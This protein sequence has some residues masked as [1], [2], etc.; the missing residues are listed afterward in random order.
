MF[1][2]RD[3]YNTKSY[4]QD[5]NPQFFQ[6]SRGNLDYPNPSAL[7]TDIVSRQSPLAPVWLAANY[8]KK[9][10][11]HQL[12]SANIVHSSSLITHHETPGTINLRLSGQLLLG[13]VRIYSRKTKYL[14]DDV[15]DILFKLKNS[16]RYATGVSSDALQVTAAPQNQVIT[17]ISSITLQ[18][19][20]T[21]LNLLY[22]EDLR[23]DDE[24]PTTLFRNLNLALP[25]DTMDTSI[26]Y[27]RNADIPDNNDVDLELD[28][29]LD[30][31][32]EMGRNAPGNN[33]AA[34]MSLMDF[35]DD[36][37]FDIGEPLQTLDAET[38]HDEIQPPKTPAQRAPRNQR[39]LK[40][41][42]VIDSPQELERGISIH[43]LKRLLQLR[44]RDLTV[45]SFDF[46]LSEQD[47]LNLIQ[48]LSTNKRRRFA[49]DSQLQEVCEELAI[50]E[51]Q[52][53]A[54][55][56]EEEPNFEFGNLDLDLSLPE[57]G[58]PQEP[59]TNNAQ[60]SVQIANLLRETFE[61][62]D[63]VDFSDIIQQDMKS[64]TPLGMKE[65][66]KVNK[67]REASK[68]FFEVLVLATNNCIS[69]DSNLTITKK[70]SIYTK[71][72]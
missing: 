33:A 68:C 40:R 61:E 54:D 41:K 22:Q 24:V 58:F 72:L 57:I 70:E 37:N 14:L 8:D 25:D 71:F 50:Q 5:K 53:K 18:D 1:T 47:K 26:E 43:E 15:N 52:H 16:F 44:L 49:L 42:L 34:D 59:I 32:I 55:H 30:Q 17:N 19:Q 13:I 12:L 67:R 35:H 60:S 51:E 10:T 56:E 9:L 66:N 63:T 4:N 31:S 20:V 7:M 6:I 21:D 11:K 29:D 28:F 48:E 39:K 2:R 46:H 38:M 65:E 23:L 45:H 27:G 36:L 64:H 62:L 69:V 3:L